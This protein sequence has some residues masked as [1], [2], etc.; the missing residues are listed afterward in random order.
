MEQCPGSSGSISI[1][2]TEIRSRGYRVET[3]RGNVY[4]KDGAFYYEVTV[5]TNGRIWIGWCSSKFQ[6]SDEAIGSDKHSWGFEG[7]DTP[8][9]SHDGKSEGFGKKWKEGSV[10]GC[11]LDVAAGTI[12]YWL[13]GA[14]LGIA[15]H[16]VTVPSSG[17]CP[18]VSLKNNQRVAINLGKSEMKYQQPGHMNLYSHLSGDGLSKLD[19]LFAKTRDIGITAGDDETSPNIQPE[20]VTKLCEQLKINPDGIDYMILAWKLGTKTPYEI[21]RFEFIGGFDRIGCSDISSMT[22]RLKEI[23]T[24]TQKD[25][26][27]FKKFYQWCFDYMKDKP[28][29][30][31]ISMDSAVATWTVVFENRFPLLQEWLAFVQDSGMKGIGH[32]A[33]RMTLKFVDTVGGDIN[34]YTEE[35]AWPVLID[36]FVDHLKSK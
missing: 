9:A 21:S 31:S 4:A 29:A 1:S 27:E 16:H 33:W 34:K 7:S 14:P 2:D 11:A 30:K 36:D 13:D 17:L 15:H 18:A 6:G 32:D 23:V 25:R 24:E 12:S 20:G 22:K 35:E 10:V 3:A 8:T 26:K 19:A 5:R 28:N